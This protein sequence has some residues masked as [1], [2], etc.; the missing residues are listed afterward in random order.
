MATTDYSGLWDSAKYFHQTHHTIPATPSLNSAQCQEASS[1]C[2]EIASFLRVNPGAWTQGALARGGDNRNVGFA[3]PWARA[4][5]MLGLLAHFIEDRDIRDEVRR[6]LTTVIQAHG[7]VPCVECFNDS[8]GRKVEEVIQMF[9][10]A[11]KLGTPML[12]ADAV[13]LVEQPRPYEE[14]AMF[15]GF[16]PQ[17]LIEEAKPIALPKWESFIEPIPAELINKLVP[18][19]KIMDQIAKVKQAA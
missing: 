19:E 16:A 8:F 18:W 14:E 1:Y 17:V 9:E 5:C 10:E 2:G 13:T 6:R 15:Y 4:W 12:S 11:Q 3:S 7:S